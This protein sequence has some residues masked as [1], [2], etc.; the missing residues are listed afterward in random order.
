MVQRGLSSKS[1]VQLTVEEMICMDREDIDDLLRTACGAGEDAVVDEYAAVAFLCSGAVEVEAVIKHP[2][3]AE[4][5]EA[6]ETLKE[7]FFTLCRLGEADET[8]RC[9]LEELGSRD[10]FGRDILESA[11]AVQGLIESLPAGKSCTE[12]GE[13]EGSC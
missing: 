12:G 9:V 6:L 13:S 11:F 8:F 3:T 2:I 1:A 5:R 4:E 7:V 10:V